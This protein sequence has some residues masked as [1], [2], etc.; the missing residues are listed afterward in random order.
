MQRHKTTADPEEDTDLFTSTPEVT[1]S[2]PS[3]SISDIITAQRKTRD[4]Q[5][6]DLQA[7]I[8]MQTE[9]LQL[10]ADALQASKAHAI[11]QAALLQRQLFSTPSPNQNTPSP[12]RPQDIA[13]KQALETQAVA[14]PAITDAPTADQKQIIQFVG[15]IVKAITRKDTSD[16]DSPPKF[17]GNDDDWEAW[18]KQLRAYLQAKGWLSTFDHPTEP[19]S[20]GFD[21]DTNNKIFTKLQNLCAKG[22]AATYVDRAAAF[23]GHGAGQELIKRYAGFSKQRLRS[24]RRFVEK[25]LRHVHGTSIV[26]HIDLFEKV[27]GYM[28][29]CGENPNDEKKIDWLLDTVTEPTYEAVNT[30]C[31]LL[32]QEGT[33]TFPKMVKLYTSPISSIPYQVS[34]GS[35]QQER[36]IICQFKSSAIW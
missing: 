26:D 27:C 20:P 3:R 4:Q 33:L 8:D 34:W 1:A 13:Y 31:V 21:I 10:T 25:K 36:Y 29:D 24:L 16:I 22:K 30:H 2:S 9:K 18:Y 28:G 23:N 15:E 12:E 19:G 5:I 32:H 17:T 7:I 35:K 11:E 14:E 6:A